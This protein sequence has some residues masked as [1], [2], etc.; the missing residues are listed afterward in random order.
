MKSIESEELI[1]LIVLTGSNQVNKKFIT[2]GLFRHYFSSINIEE[3][4][5]KLSIFLVVY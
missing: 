1:G 3:P 4:R 2:C 5:T